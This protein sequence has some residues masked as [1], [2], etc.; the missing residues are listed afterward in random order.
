MV[1][2]TLKKFVFFS[3]ATGTEIELKTKAG[4]EKHFIKDRIRFYFKED[5]TLYYDSATDLIVKESE[6]DFIPFEVVTLEGEKEV[7]R[8]STPVTIASEYVNTKRVKTDNLLDHIGD[9]VDSLNLYTHFEDHPEHAGNYYL[10]Q[11]E[12]RQYK[13]YASMK[14]MQTHEQSENLYINGHY[15]FIIRDLSRWYMHSGVLRCKSDNDSGGVYLSLVK[16]GSGIY[17]REL[18]TVVVYDSVNTRTD[19]MYVLAIE[20]I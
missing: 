2:K 6:H 18:V 3:S 20:E 9:G 19:Y 11:F 7:V 10:P 4:T 8:D 5:T 12:G 13:V 16:N 15:E 17:T 14:A 1:K